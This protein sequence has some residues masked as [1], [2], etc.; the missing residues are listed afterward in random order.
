M[1]KQKDQTAP[2]ARVFLPS[3]QPPISQRVE[4]GPDPRT[5]GDNDARLP[6]TLYLSVEKGHGP[7]PAVWRG[8]GAWIHVETWGV[9]MKGE[10]R[11]EWVFD[12]CC[13]YVASAYDIRVKWSCGVLRRRLVSS[14]VGGQGGDRA[15]KGRNEIGSMGRTLE[16]LILIALGRLL[17]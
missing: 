8:N 3:F 7:T 13:I 16:L 11:V 12:A 2:V 15:M 17:G 1:V 5:R 14:L 4:K 10:G 9:G 6:S